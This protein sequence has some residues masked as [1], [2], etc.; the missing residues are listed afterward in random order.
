MR[1]TPNLGTNSKVNEEL[2]KF[3]FIKGDVECKA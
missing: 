2:G 3:T 1:D